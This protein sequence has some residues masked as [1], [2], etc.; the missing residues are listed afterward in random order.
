MAEGYPDPPTRSDHVVNVAAR[1]A[2]GLKPLEWD[3]DG[4]ACRQGTK[5]PVRFTSKRQEE[6]TYGPI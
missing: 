3:S 4:Q 1:V 6:W 2:V 5:S